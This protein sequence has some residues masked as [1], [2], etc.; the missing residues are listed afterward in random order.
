MVS[1]IL[2]TLQL[3]VI[4]TPKIPSEYYCPRCQSE[5]IFVYDNYIECAQCGLNFFIEDIESDVDRENLLSEQE[6]KAVANAFN[7]EE[8]K[9][10][11]KFLE[12]DFS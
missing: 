6:L 3:W 4:F 10:I 7:E 9:K 11:L 8:R 5:D 2:I 12:D 1:I